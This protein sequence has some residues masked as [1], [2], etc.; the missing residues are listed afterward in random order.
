MKIGILTFHESNN[1][2]AVLQAYALQKIINRYNFCDLIDYRADAISA[3]G[4][5][6]KIRTSRGIKG[7]LKRILTLSYYENKN[8]NF[9]K[10]MKKCHLSSR[11]YEAA[12]IQDANQEYDCFITGSDQVFN[13]DLTHNDQI[14]YLDF[15]NAGKKRIAYAASL[16]SYQITKKDVAAIKLLEYM[17]NI[18]CREPEAAKNVASLINRDVE[19]VLDPTLL[20][21]KK[22]WMELEEILPNLPPKYILLYLISPKSIYFK[23]AIK[24]GRKLNLPILYI[25]YSPKKWRNMRIKNLTD[26]TPEQFLFLIHNAE[27]IITNS[28]HGTA[29]SINYEKNFYVIQD[30]EK[31]RSNQRIE[32]LL[33][34]LKLENR[35]I[36]NVEEVGKQSINYDDRRKRLLKEK[37]NSIRFL[38]K[39]GVLDDE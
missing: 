16:G 27:Y 21:T 7:V 11:S 6:E 28:F 32:R 35:M 3:E 22:E 18:S 8:K 24:I 14:F 13:L 26:V 1:Y 12:N 37:E 5:I 17:D 4:K 33:H 25:N 31:K 39:A 10:F 29:F 30:M 9:K 2:G 34:I 23:L 20:L 15:V 38:K 19:I 36:Q